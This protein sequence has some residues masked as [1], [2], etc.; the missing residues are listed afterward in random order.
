MRNLMLFG[1]LLLPVAAGAYHYGPGQAAVRA[2]RAAD[3]AHEAAELAAEARRIQGLDGDAAARG[4]FGAAVEAYE[5]ALQELPPGNDA[6][7]R[8]LRLE[9]A[10]AR[11]FVSQLPEAH[12]DLI[13]LVDELEEE[14]NADAQLLSQARSALANAQY[15]RTWL[16]RL[17]GAPRDEWEPEIE[18]SRQNFRLVAETAAARGDTEVAR[19]S[20]QDL[21]ASVRLARMEL[22]D[23]QGLPLPSQ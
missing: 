1:W 13:S 12:R 14:P 3:A 7:S 4:T 11:M 19:L 22:S 9:L 23:L 17:E 18:A 6:Q 20:E 2:D 5:R 10:K 8:A 21:E 16:M 15:Y